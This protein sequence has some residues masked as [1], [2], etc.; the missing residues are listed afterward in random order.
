SAPQLGV[1][2][3]VFAAELTPE[4]CRRYPPEFRRAHSIEPFPLRLFV[5][6]ALRVL[7][8]RLVSAPEGCASI[9]GFSAYVPRHWAVHVS[10]VDAGGEP[11]SWEAKGWAARIAQH[12]MDHLDGTLYIDHMDTRTFTNV[13]WMQ[14]LD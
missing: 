2:L 3:R 12:E 7:D 4:R 13:N 5:N 9:K 8:S 6:P 11:V 10:G 14:L 1:P